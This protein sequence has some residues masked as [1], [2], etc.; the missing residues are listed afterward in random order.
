MLQKSRGRVPPFPAALLFSSPGSHQNIDLFPLPFALLQSRPCPFPQFCCLPY[1]FLRWLLV[2]RQRSTQS[3][4]FIMQS[5]ATSCSTYYSDSPPPPLEKKLKI[6][7]YSPVGRC[8]I[9]TRALFYSNEVF[10]SDNDPR[11]PRDQISGPRPVKPSMDTPI[12]NG[13]RSR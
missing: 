11:K 2:F 1:F 8:A 7:K 9:R 5:C 6:Y 3:A 10:G 4:R 12:Q 13:S